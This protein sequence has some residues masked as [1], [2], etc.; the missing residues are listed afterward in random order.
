[1]LLPGSVAGDAALLPQIDQVREALDPYHAA[2]RQIVLDAWRTW[3]RSPY[4]ARWRTARGR[5]NFVW[6][7]IIANALTALDGDPSA[8]FHRSHGSFWLVIDGCLVVRFKK[9]DVAGYSCNYPTTAALRF[10]DP[11]EPLPN[12]A[13]VQRVQVQYTLNADATDLA[14]IRVVC[15][16]GERIEWSYS[17]LASESVPSVLPVPT[18]PER[19]TSLDRLLRPRG[20]SAPQPLAGEATQG[21]SYRRG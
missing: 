1:M 10:H 19:S 14:D 18:D 15:R 16:N 5:A 2:I 12:I 3:A 11:Q 7:E 17:L 9:A 13:A 6:E 8:H 4:A 21:T 20:D